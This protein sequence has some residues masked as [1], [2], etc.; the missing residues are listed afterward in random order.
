MIQ[1]V[2]QLKELKEKGLMNEEILNNRYKVAE[3]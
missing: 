3:A 2:L 1:N